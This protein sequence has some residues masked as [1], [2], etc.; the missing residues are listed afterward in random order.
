V[1]LKDKEYSKQI[2]V[3]N[4]LIYNPLITFNH[5][6]I[7]PILQKLAGRLS[8]YLYK[9]YKEDI[10]ADFTL[11]LPSDPEMINKQF[12]TLGMIARDAADNPY[13]LLVLN[14]YF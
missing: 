7:R 12:T 2:A 10:Y 14:T 4:K 13:S 1:P 8:I 6:V 3:P 9:T 11:P 5:S